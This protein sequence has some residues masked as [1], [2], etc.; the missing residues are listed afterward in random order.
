M[1]HASIIIENAAILTMAAE[2]PRAEAMAISGNRILAV[3]NRAEILKL[4][5]PNTRHLDAGGNTVMPGFVEAHLHIF[6]GS[7]DLDKLHLSETQGFAALS[8]A[9]RAYASSRPNET[10]LIAKGANYTILGDTTPL[11]RQHLDEIS[12]DRALFLYAP[13]HHTAW[14]NTIALEKAGILHGRDVGVGNEIVIGKDGFA[15]GEL[16]EGLAMEPVLALRN[17]GGRERLGLEGTEPDAS[18]S[19]AERAEDI[20]TLKA[21]LKYL[22]RHGITSFHNMDGNFYQL[23]LLKQIEAEGELLCR[24]EIPFHLTNSK[25]LSS[26]EQASEMARLYNSDMLKSGRVKIFIDGVLDSG[27]AVLVDEYA[28]QPGWR[29]DLLFTPEAF[30]QAA[31][32]IDRRGLQ[33]SVHAIG[34]MAVRTVLDG[35]QAAREANGPRDSRHRIEHIELVHPDDIARFAQLSVIASMQPPHPPGSMGLPLEPTL[36]KI[37]PARWPYA[38]AWRSLWNAGARICFASDWPVSPLPPMLGVHAAVTRQKWQA[39]LPDQSASLNEALAAYSADGAYTGFMEEKIG[40]L[41]SGML[42]DIVI[43]SANVEAIDPVALS[44]VE[45]LTTICDGRITYQT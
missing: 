30:K 5:G 44:S 35:Y 26:L 13:D 21:G 37:G 20:A 34:D 32:E 25:P 31:I 15:T 2:N 4:K 9:I 45:P 1:S 38:Y 40:K 11:S 36:S 14:A 22:A 10:L 19:P 7:A 8:K 12:P 42:A 33:I 16:R 27:T 23:E 18:L 43:L 41:K 39:N 28:D 17:S 24:A 29:G 3:G 6:G